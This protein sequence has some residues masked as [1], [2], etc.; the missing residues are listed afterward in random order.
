MTKYFLFI[1]ISAIVLNASAQEKNVT[2]SELVGVWQDIELVASG[3][4]NTFLF[5]PDGSY[6][7]Y[8]NQMDCMKRVIMHSGTWKIKDDGL[9]IKIK[10]RKILEGGQIV[11]SNTSCDSTIINGIEIIKKVS[12]SE[13]EILSISPLY[14]DKQNDKH[15]IYLDAISFWR[16]SD[17]PDELLPEFEK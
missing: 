14:F 5:F 7:F 10:N 2:K 6:R 11:T 1:I 13:K 9:V 12:P 16:F 3:W 17:K 4:S 8:Y 15:K